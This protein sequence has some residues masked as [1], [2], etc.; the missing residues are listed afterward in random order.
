[1]EKVNVK[2]LELG[3]TVAR[4]LLH[5]PPQYASV[6]RGAP[7]HS[8]GLVI[9][10]HRHRTEQPDTA[11]TINPTKATK[12]NM[13]ALSW[14]MS[15][16]STTLPWKY[17]RSLMV[18]VA[19]FASAWSLHNAHARRQSMS[20][21]HQR[22][23]ARGGTYKAAESVDSAQLKEAPSSSSVPI[24]PCDNTNDGQ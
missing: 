4:R 10:K 20:A 22:V 7:P 21:A 8:S 19:Q 14:Y 5:K 24:N 12:P 6:S 18:N 16:I 11:R 2:R 23:H 3:A 13:R 17:A 9:A 15:R 1:M